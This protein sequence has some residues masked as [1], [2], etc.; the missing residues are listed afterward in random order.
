ME[1]I[2][3]KIEEII[4]KQLEELEKNPIRSS[5]RLFIWYWIAKTIWREIKR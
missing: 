5:I 2:M 1:K 3:E 4:E